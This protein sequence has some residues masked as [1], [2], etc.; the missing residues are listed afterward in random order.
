MPEDIRLTVSATYMNIRTAERFL[1]NVQSGIPTGSVE[2]LLQFVGETIDKLEKSNNPRLNKFIED[3]K[4]KLAETFEKAKSII[5]DKKR[6]QD[7]IYK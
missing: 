2:Y 4:K 6:G 7:G 3:H 5:G 1:V